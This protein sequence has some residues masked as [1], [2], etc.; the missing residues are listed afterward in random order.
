MED[1]DFKL[2]KRPGKAEFSGRRRTTTRK[3]GFKSHEDATGGHYTVAEAQRFLLDAEG[4][5]DIYFEMP[6]ISKGKFSGFGFYFNSDGPLKI[7]VDASGIVGTVAS[8]YDNSAW[9]KCGYIWRR[10]HPTKLTVEIF[11]KPHQ[12]LF[13]FDASCGEIWHEYYEASREAVIRNIQKFAPEANFYI[14]EGTVD[15]SAEPADG[16][17]EIYL[18]ECNRCARTLPVNFGNERA[19]LSFSN[20]C[21]ARRPCKH[22]GFGILE[23]EDTGELLQL[24]YGFQL[25]CRVC[26]KFVVNAALNPQRTADQMK[27]DAQRRRHFELLIMELYQGSK[28]LQYRHTSGKELPT[29]IWEKFEKKC[30]NCNVELPNAKVMNLDHTRPLALLWPLDE[31]AT[32]LCK[33][34]NS[35]KRDRYPSDFYTKTKLKDLSK[36]TGININELENP[37]PNMEV[38]NLLVERVDWLIEDFLNKDFLMK[39]KAG[40]I[41]SELICKALDRV[42]ALSELHDTGFSF[43]ERWSNYK[44]S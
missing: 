44:R 2:Q 30:F 7:H 35:A 32:A 17:A 13:L 5:L 10:D 6:P 37:S 1:R 43:V 15:V 3:S 31:T 27:E 41:S 20:H 25:E 8:T 36:I 11:G 24:E 26:K 19:T 18:K 12:E 22:K 38:L 14:R 23:L 34:C 40:K 29:F 21:V 4:K 16:I 42:I 9:N 33:D 28:Q 39:E